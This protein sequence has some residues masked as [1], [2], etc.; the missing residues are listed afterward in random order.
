MPP[1]REVEFAIEVVPGTN[2]VFKKHYRMTSP[3]LVE[4]KKQLDD[5]IAKGFIRPSTS[6]WGSPVLFVKKSD[7]TL[8]LCIDYRALN[9]VTIK[10]KYP[11]S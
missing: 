8:C 11:L 7:R 5:L 4:L 1:D 9:E 2:P 3:E 10:N 6:P